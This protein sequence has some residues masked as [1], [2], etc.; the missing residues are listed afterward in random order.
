MSDTYVNPFFVGFEKNLKEF[1]APCEI[2]NDCDLIALAFFDNNFKEHVKII[3]QL[4]PKT[5]KL[6]IYLSEPTAESGVIDILKRYA[7]HKKIYMFS[8]IVLNVTVPNNNF[9]TVISWFISSKNF[10]RSNIKII[11]LLGKLHPVNE[12]VP[13]KAMFDCLLGT[14]RPHRDLVESLYNRSL[15]QEKII[16]T[17]YKD[18]KNINEGLWEHLDTSSNRYAIIPTS[19]YNQSYYSIVA[20]TL[21]YNSFSFYTEKVAKPILARRPFVVF[22]GQYYLKNLKKI[23]FKT[24]DSVIDESYDSISD[25]ESRVTAAWQQVEWLCNQDPVKI[26]SQLAD[27]LEHNRRHFLNTD[28]HAAI[29]QHFGTQSR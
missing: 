13:R 16:F 11:R 9:S 27:I 14:A 19:V 10:Y 15:N 8:D 25:L 18:N 6:L 3:D 20:E 28:W 26:Y 2:V 4:I 22:A 12:Q 5:K 29:R 1:N 21:T 24:F 17:Y 7:D 23:G